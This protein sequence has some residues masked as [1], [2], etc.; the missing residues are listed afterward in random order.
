MP[1]KSVVTLIPFFVQTVN[2]FHFLSF[3]GLYFIFIST[4]LRGEIVKFRSVALLI[5]FRE[6]FIVVYLICDVYLCG[7][8][9]EEEGVGWGK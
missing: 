7:H 6:L 9:K 2:I 3:F 5:C 8:W 1:S 4:F